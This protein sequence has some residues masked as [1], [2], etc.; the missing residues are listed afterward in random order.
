V[1]DKPR[2]DENVSPKKV[3]ELR[4]A[5]GLPMMKVKEALVAEG[6]DFEKAKDRLRKEGL[7][8]ADSKA[9]RATGNGLVRSSVSGNGRFGAMVCVLCETE[10]VAKTKLFTDFVDALLVHVETKRPESVLALTS[11][12]W[13][14]DAGATPQRTVDEVRRGLVAQIGE[15][16]VVAGV[17]WLEVK[18]SGLAGTYVHHDQRSGGLV[19]V[20][21]ATVTP[22]A[23]ETVRQL[24]MHLV[25]AR[26]IALTRS[27]V[28][29]DLVDR[30]RE[31][32]REATAQDPKMKGK[33]PQVVEKIVE[34][35]V[36]AFYKERVL[37][38]QPWFK[39]PS[40]SV[41]QMLQPFGG[42]LQGYAIAVVGGVAAAC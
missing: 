41:A 40:K 36:D 6:G 27:D 8:A 17:W 19:T 39:D 25:F 42:T 15:N 37:G 28:P 33:P 38:E 26:P 11:Q 10:P 1:A 32:L 4:A 21:A 14:R 24:A 18:G 7:K 13:A 9:G 23:Q 30:E 5:T 16:I 29:R 2:D 31:I 12:L 35:K 22:E 3:M 20:G 34:G